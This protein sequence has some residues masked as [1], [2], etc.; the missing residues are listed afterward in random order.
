MATLQTQ[1]THTGNTV[2][3][4]IAGK[5]VG[6]AQ[7]IN[8]SRSFGTQAQ[9][10][11]GSA[12]PVEHVYGQYEGTVTL[13]RIRM[14]TDSLDQLGLVALGED[15]LQ[16]DVIDIVVMDNLNQQVIVAYRGC[17]ANDLSETFS[18]GQGATESAT[19]SFLESRSVK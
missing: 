7:D 4:M 14:K 6:M 16:K 5:V 15:I 9:Y 18:I 10:E 1:K 8:G 17:T 3:L 13:N 19:F 12:M 11:L 2:Y